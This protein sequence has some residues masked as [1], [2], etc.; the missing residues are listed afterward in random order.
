MAS[1][2]VLQDNAIELVDAEIVRIRNRNGN[3]S[4][5][6]H[7]RLRAH[8]SVDARELNTEKLTVGIRAAGEPKVN[9]AITVLSTSAQKEVRIGNGRVTAAT[10]RLAAVETHHVIVGTAASSEPK[11]NG[12]IEVRNRN[13]ATMV[14]IDG[15]AGD[16]KFGNDSV[17]ARLL[18]FEAR[19]SRLERR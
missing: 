16:I 10:G 18:R 3:V 14:K 15:G 2:V 17:K 12:V 13:G 5:T 1:D 19:L 9:G 8:T 4:V 11:A 7:G 6:I